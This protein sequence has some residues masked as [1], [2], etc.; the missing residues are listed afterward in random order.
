MYKTVKIAAFIGGAILCSAFYSSAQ[1]KSVWTDLNFVRQSEVWLQSNNAAGLKYMPVDTISEI[2][3][4]GVSGKGSFVNY[5][6][7]DQSY[8]YGALAESYFRLNKK[9]VLF[10]NI[11]YTNF[12]GKNMGAS[13]WIDPDF[14]PFNLVEYADTTRGEKSM[15]SYHL[16]GATAIDLGKKI[17]VGGKMD[18]LSANYVKKKD[19]RHLNMLMDLNLS[20]GVLYQLGAL[21]EV[22]LNYNY[23]KRVEETN[24][25]TY[26]N[27]DRTYS[28]LIS[29]GTFWGQVEGFGSEGFTGEGDNNPLVDKTNGLSLQ[30]NL[31]IKPRL[32]YFNEFTLNKREGYFGVQSDQTKVYTDHSVDILAYRGSLLYRSPKVLHQLHLQ[33]SNEKLENWKTNYYFDV[34]PGSGIEYVKYYAPTK[35]LVR[36]NLEAAVEY[37]LHSGYDGF[38]PAWSFVA[39]A[40]YKSREQKVSFYPLY[41]NQTVN[42]LMGKAQVKRNI[43]SGKN[44]YTFLLGTLLSSGSGTVL[45]AGNYAGSTDTSTNYRST[46]FNLYREY[47]YLTAASIIA[48]A[49]FKY[50]RLLRQNKIRA[51]AGVN[52]ERMKAGDIEY[53]KGDFFNTVSFSIGCSF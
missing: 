42:Q 26:G 8:S 39:G 35:V 2:S 50:A 4:S 44:Q 41:R 40:A 53:S 19:M 5:N 28:T 29:W 16:T 9:V 31:N 37:Q 17:S 47:E 43:V 27:T 3:F 34:D 21:G 7:S 38:N 15:E 33:A 12:T 20:L 10:G 23:R 51:F 1:E 13:A 14:A 18:Y 11:S 49:G 48:Q 46:D 32:R 36:T 45:D 24:F 30:V 6:Q 52:Y 25:D 22:G